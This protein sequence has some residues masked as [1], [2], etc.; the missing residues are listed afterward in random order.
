MVTYTSYEEFI[1]TRAS[2]SI[3]KGYNETGDDFQTPPQDYEIVLDMA[4]NDPIIA[5]A[6]DLTVDLVTFN[7][8]K[9]VSTNESKPNER[10]IKR[11]TNVFNNVLD[12][13]QVIDPV[14]YN[15]LI[16][17][18][19]YLELRRNGNNEIKELFSLPTTEMKVDFDKHGTIQG[20][21]QKP[22]N[23]RYGNV[24]FSADE[25]L[26][27]K[28]KQIGNNVYSETPFL[29]IASSY[30][31]K[32]F[33]NKYLQEL[34]RN[35]P[36]KILYALENA[37]RAEREL[38]MEN[39]RRG[40]T[41][42][43]L[44]LVGF[45]K[46]DANVLK[47][48]IDGGFLQVLKDIRNEVLTV[49]RIPV[50]WVDASTT[51][52]R[53]IGESVVIP[54][55][56]KIKKIQAKVASLINKVLMPALG[57]SNIKFQWNP[58]SL[59]DEKSV[60]EIAGKLSAMNLDGDSVL[61]YLRLKGIE[62]PVDAKI[63]EPMEQLGDSPGLTGPQIQKDASPSRQRM[64]KSTD[65]MTSNLNK[66]GVSE[67]GGKKLEEK[68]MQTRSSMDFNKYPYTIEVKG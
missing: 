54:Y 62:L 32:I 65:K 39:L 28:L 48:V 51:P 40:K 52:N 4:R 1:Q 19:S 38:F 64:D 7:G 18:D 8:F 3:T 6:L 12:F 26:Y 23:N 44:D 41:D 57:F 47:L 29:P 21:V 17:G 34:F 15:L 11:A 35:I 63:E 16:F 9:F 43:A 66:S 5:T 22:Q 53:G 45:G 31:T 24:P 58:T 27:F 61:S 25:V 49:F 36:P 59:T 2:K 13:D 20:Y 30:T 68:R 60:V 50:H 55:D 37:N 42:P 14:L 10:E 56:T 33:A 67:A 46:V